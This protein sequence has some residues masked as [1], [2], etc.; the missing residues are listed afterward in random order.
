MP[1]KKR[2]EVRGNERKTR[3]DESNASGIREQQT[4]DNSSNNPPNDTPAPTLIILRRKSNTYTQSMGE[5]NPDLELDPER[6]LKTRT[7]AAPRRSR[8]RH[9]SALVR[10]R[11]R[12]HSCHHVMCAES[13]L[14]LAKERKQPSAHHT[15]GSDTKTMRQHK[16][17]ARTLFVG[18][19][20]HV[21]EGRGSKR[22][23]PSRAYGV[24][25]IGCERAWV[26]G[27]HQWSGGA[28]TAS[29]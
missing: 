14:I 25:R 29:P 2:K 4:H 6:D 1:P 19:P 24:E 16:Q 5:T 21:T 7:D 15:T 28:L 22:L 20:V 10:C 23:V 3:Y 12:R 18:Q 17:K 11:L 13:H 8:V 26:R 27:M 9:L